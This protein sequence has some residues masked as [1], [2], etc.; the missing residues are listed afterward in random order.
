[1]RTLEVILDDKTY[2]TAL[3]A[4]ALCGQDTD[5]WVANAIAVMAEVDTSLPNTRKRA[6]PFITP[7]ALADRWG[8]SVDDLASA[9]RLHG[10]PHPVM[11]AGNTLY[12]LKD[13]V[14]YEN[15]MLERQG[16]K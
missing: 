16:V 6:Q 1:M 4:S 3:V 2:E 8:I 13:V 9:P 5:E 11:I 14:V 12:R 15:H 7:Q 10:T